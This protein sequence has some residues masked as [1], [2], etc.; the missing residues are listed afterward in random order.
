ITKYGR[1]I[2]LGQAAEQSSVRVLNS[3]TVEFIIRV[4]S[5]SNSTIYNVI[6]TDL[7]PAGV[8]YLSRTTSVNNTIVDDS[9]INGLNIGSLAPGQE[10]TI[11]FSGRINAVLS[12]PS[13]S[14][15]A[16]NTAQARADNV[17][18]VSAQLPLTLGTVAGVSTGPT[19]S[20]FL[21]LALSGLV[22]ALYAAYTRT[23][24]FQTRLASATARQHRADGLNF[25]RFI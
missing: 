6:V 5:L 7:L 15:T 8:E 25:H 14:L 9:I 10:T 18:T 21:A 4:R 22:T 12:F 3:N 13:G 19:E 17:P 1:N 20:L 23:G 24:L 2:T 16:Y 11:R